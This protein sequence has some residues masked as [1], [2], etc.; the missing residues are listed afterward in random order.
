MAASG[1]WHD[2]S[3]DERRDA[4]EA[5]KQLLKALPRN[6]EESDVERQ[7]QLP[8]IGIAPWC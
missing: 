8:E 2:A 1:T 3:L 7:S 5:E 4:Y 6:G